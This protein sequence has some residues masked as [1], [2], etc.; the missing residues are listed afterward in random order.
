MGRFDDG[1]EEK[2]L[3]RRA[4]ADELPESIVTKRKFPYR[5]PDSAAFAS[6]RP[7]YLE[8]LLSEAELAKLPFIDA[9]FARR[10]TD[11][12]LNRPADEIGTKEDQCFVFLLSIALL[13]R[14]FVQR[15]GAGLTRVT[16]PPMRTVD[17]RGK[18]LA[19]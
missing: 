1:F 6:A 2:R 10:L 17:L 3:L 11:K 9:K 13:H 18:P 14:F 19:A 15:E 7:D 5:A 16:P 8:A 12:V 4:F